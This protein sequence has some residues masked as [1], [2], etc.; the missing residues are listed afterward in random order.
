MAR[1]VGLVA[2]VLVVVGLAGGYAGKA[3]E[4]ATL[5]GQ[6]AELE[7]R[8]AD[9]EA[10]QLPPVSP[11]ITGYPVDWREHGFL[12]NC[13]WRSTDPTEQSEV[14]AGVCYRP[15]SVPHPDPNP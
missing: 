14:S 3:R 4:A 12:L 10:N 5:E 2:F 11:G 7:A 15:A 13:T 6:V 9:L 1:V 8:V